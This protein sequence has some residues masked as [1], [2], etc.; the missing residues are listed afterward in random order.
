MKRTVLQKQTSFYDSLTKRELSYPLGKE[1]YL[2][3]LEICMPMLREKKAG[4][5]VTT[6]S[7]QNYSATLSPP[8]IRPMVEKY[9]FYKL[10]R[11]EIKAQKRI[12]ECA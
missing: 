1:G 4:T 3:K 5:S 2:G 10:E 8:P 6:Q 11:T 12:E 7:S 9:P